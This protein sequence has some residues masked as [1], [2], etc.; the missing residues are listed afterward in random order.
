MQKFDDGSPEN[1]VPVTRHHVTGTGHVDILAMG[2]D[3]QEV[4]GTIFAQ[5]VG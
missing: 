1:I 4:P 5:Q 2:T 3:R